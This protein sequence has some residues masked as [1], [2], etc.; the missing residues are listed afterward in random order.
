MLGQ[1]PDVA[2][3]LVR[4]YDSHQLYE[5]AENEAPDARGELTDVVIDL[6]RVPLSDTQ[7]ELVTDVLM[8]LMRQA[9]IDL[10]MAV[11][12]RLATLDNVPLRMVLHMA[13]D[14]IKVADPVLRNSPLLE[15]MDLIYI[16]KAKGA[17][18]WRAI[19]RREKIGVNVV[20]SLAETRDLTTA[21]T[22][23]KNSNVMLSDKALNIFSDMA[24]TSDALASPLLHR[25]DIPPQMAA[26]LYDYVGQELKAYISENYSDKDAAA[27]NS[28][29][30]DVT[31]EF[32]NAAILNFEPS[33]QMVAAAGLLMEKGSLKVDTILQALRR[34]QYAYFVALFSAWC[35]IPVTT[36]GQIAR[37]TNGQ[38][39]A[40]ACRATS[41]SKGDFMTIYLLTGRIRNGGVKIVGQGELSAALRYFD[42]VSTAQARKILAQ[43]K[44]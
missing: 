19:A 26:K 30:D 32:K 42:K 9:E 44:Q 17:E 33:A 38:G 39:L 15:D 2:P 16:I 34:G 36:A 31:L 3:L 10:R 27:I 13:N 29:L 40:V 1:N 41:I 25:A 20:D 8:T 14:E 12:D 7:K 28:A 21:V 5:L 35:G 43:S 4:L 23:A 37:Q 22:L 24:M 6:L 18:H 11:A